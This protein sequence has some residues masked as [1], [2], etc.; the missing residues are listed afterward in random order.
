MSMQ[1]PVELLPEVVRRYGQ[2]AY[3]AVSDPAGPPRVTHVM[4]TFTGATLTFGLGRTSCALLEAN[5]H[6]S[7]L[8]PAT[9]PETM[10]LIVDADVL[11]VAA[12]GTV[13]V[14]AAAAVRHRPAPEPEAHDSM[15]GA[16]GD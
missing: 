6:L 1:V 3:A 11:G 12:D 13:T 14:R 15:G 9:H 7:L 5:P 10:S 4:P 2:S 16:S 8:W